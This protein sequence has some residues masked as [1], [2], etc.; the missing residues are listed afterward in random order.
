MT[1]II[2]AFGDLIVATSAS[3]DVCFAGIE[4]SV[5][6]P[7]GSGELAEVRGLRVYLEGVRSA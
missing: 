3:T 1:T 6:V 2:S 4:L 7:A 5:E